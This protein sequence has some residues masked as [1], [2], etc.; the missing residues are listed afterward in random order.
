MRSKSEALGE[1]I[2]RIA[3]RSARSIVIRENEEFH[4]PRHEL[5]EGCMH[6]SRFWRCSRVIIP[7]AQVCSNRVIDDR[8]VAYFVWSL[9]ARSK[10][11]LESFVDICIHDSSILRMH[12][13]AYRMPSLPQIKLR[14]KGKL[15]TYQKRITFLATADDLLTEPAVSEQFIIG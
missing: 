2:D 13:R 9:S 12:E 6:G 4:L 5:S 11:L 15:L 1:Q 10:T 8:F 7:V 14:S 3:D